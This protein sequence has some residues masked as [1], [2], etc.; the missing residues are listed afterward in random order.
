MDYND[1]RSMLGI[2]RDI[3]KNHNTNLLMEDEN[4]SNI[5]ETTLNSIRDLFKEGISIDQVNVNE[6]KT[7]VLIKGNILSMNIDFNIIIKRTINDSTCTVDFGN[8]FETSTVITVNQDL[9]DN[10]LEINEL[11][12][13]YR[14]VYEYILNNNILDLDSDE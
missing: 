5:D 2:M 8:M 12:S 1:M 10:L 13:S 3:N 4:N 7:E 14:E 6:S 11:Y 9:V